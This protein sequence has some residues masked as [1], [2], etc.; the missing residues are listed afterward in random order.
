M[1]ASGLMRINAEGMVQIYLSPAGALDAIEPIVGRLGGRMERAD[2]AAHLVQA[3]L[4][5]SAL[6]E[7]S[8]DPAVKFVRLPDYGFSQAGS[9]TTEGDQIL[10]AN[11][12]RSTFGVDG[13]GVRVGVISN[14][15]GG[16]EASTASGDLPPNVNITTCN[17]V[18]GSDPRAS[19]AEGTAMLEIV[20]DLA[21]GA[22][23]W[24]GNWAFATALDFNAAVTCLA[25]NTDVVVDDISFFLSGPYD[26]TSLIS[27][28]TSAQLN[29]ASNHVRLYSTAVANLATAH[30]RELFHDSGFTFA[31]GKY[32]VHAFGATSNTTD[33]GVGRH[34][35]G[36]SGPYCFDSVLVKAG[37][38]LTVYLR[39]DD[40]ENSSNDYDLFLLDRTT[41]TVVAQSTNPQTGSQPPIEAL[42]WTNNHGAGFFDILVGLRSGTPKRLNLWLPT[43]TH[44]ACNKLS[45]GA[46]HN[47]NTVGSSV[48]LEADAGGGVLSVGAIKA[49]NADDPNNVQIEPYSS[50]GPTADGRTKPDITGTDC[51]G[52]TGAGGFST[53]FCGTSAA[54]PHI[55]GIAALLLQLRPDLKAGGGT[56][57]SVARGYLS[58]VLRIG[59]YRLGTAPDNVFGFGRA[60][61]LA[62]A[63]GL[64]VTVT[65]TSTGSYVTYMNP[66]GTAAVPVQDISALPCP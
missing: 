13:T 46:F 4:P 62:A 34:C 66:N 7:I 56:D 60:N 32:R 22:E 14:G 37:Q 61:A 43:C 50:Q 55:A 65:D 2:R 49:N 25:A 42:A 28:N 33:G 58:Q 26:G 12:V 18:A 24:F 21:P 17:V 11:L 35:S 48:P 20:H 15:V 63:E 6:E 8:A 29:N 16:L 30:Y 23:L 27:A 64:R 41:G 9:V 31:N 57:P 40:S 44:G 19:G 45:N 54:A 59:A 1:V 53:S 36:A 3:W 47:F 38:T 52:V 51:V 39:W 5:L 10:E